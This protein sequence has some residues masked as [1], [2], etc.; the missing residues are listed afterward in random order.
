MRSFL[1]ASLLA[2]A[3][4]ALIAQTP[5]TPAPLAFFTRLVGEWEGESWIV[6]GPAGKQ[7]AQQREVVEAVAG[8]TVFTIKG[9]GKSTQPD[10]SVRITHD[11]FALVY[12]DHDHLTP[13]M[14]SH[15]AYG[16][17]WLDPDFTLTADGFKWSMTDARSGMIRYAMSFDA[18]GRWVEQGEMSRDEGK[19][20]TPFFEMTLTKKE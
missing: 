14:R 19:T 1:L 10:G 18:E 5:G 8:G 4:I 7:T 12:L 15:V 3:P 20:W 13:R 6:M 11:A 9:L 16:G 17:N 2:A